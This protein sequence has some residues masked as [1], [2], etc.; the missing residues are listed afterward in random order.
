MTTEEIKAQV[1]LAMAAVLHYFVGSKKLSFAEFE[2]DLKPFLEAYLKQLP[3]FD[4]LS[5]KLH[6]F[7][8]GDRF[9]IGLIFTDCWIASQLFEVERG[10][11][12][13][14]TLH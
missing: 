14:T 3:T 6:P 11:K 1:E 2:A 13:T 8:N 4:R 5:Y 10:V 12:A 7:P 9:D